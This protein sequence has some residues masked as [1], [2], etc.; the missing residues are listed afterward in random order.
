MEEE[1]LVCRPLVAIQC[2]VFNNFSQQRGDCLKSFFS[3]LHSNSGGMEDAAGVV[4]L[5]WSG[6]TRVRF[7]TGK[8]YICP[9]RNS[10]TGSRPRA[11]LCS[12]HTGCYFYEASRPVL[13]FD[14]WRGKEWTDLYLH[15]IA[16]AGKTPSL[17]TSQ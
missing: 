7:P 15:L 3:F 16:C 17:C 9:L 4:T 13:S 10:R 14:H 5:L 6:P 8:I 2:K 12:M 1:L 11:P